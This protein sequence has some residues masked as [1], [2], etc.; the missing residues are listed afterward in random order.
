MASKVRASMVSAMASL[1]KDSELTAMAM[2]LLLADTD[3]NGM[4]KKENF[5][6]FMELAN[7]NPLLRRNMKTLQELQ[8]SSLLVPGQVGVGQV[9]NCR[10]DVKLPSLTNGCTL[11]CSGKKSTAIITSPARTGYRT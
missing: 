4:P 10:V 2:K 1:P 8:L 11:M 3:S 5:Q 6:K 7:N 9:L